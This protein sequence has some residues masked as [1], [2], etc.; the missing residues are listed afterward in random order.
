MRQ[1]RL[2]IATGLLVIGLDVLVVAAVTEAAAAS[3]C[4]CIQ[5]GNSCVPDP[6]CEAL[7]RAQQAAQRA[8]D[9][10]RRAQEAAQR[11]QEAAQRAQEA[12]QRAQDERSRDDER[13]SPEQRSRQSLDSPA[14]GGSPPPAARPASPPATSPPPSARAPPRNGSAPL[15]RSRPPASAN[16]HPPAAAAPAAPAAPGPQKSAKLRILETGYSHLIELGKEVD[17]YGLY[18]YAIL[19]SDSDR[20]ALFLGE[21]FKEIPS[22][23]GTSARPSQLNI[24]YIPLRKDKEADLVAMLRTPGRDAGK[25]GAEYTKSFYDYR[26]AR[27][28]LDHVCNPPDPSVLDLCDGALSGGPYIFA[29]ASPASKMEPVPPPFLFVDLSD[30][31]ERAF[32]EFLAAFQAQVKREDISDQARI[33]TLRLRILDIALTAADWVG[34]V[35]KAVADIARSAGGDDKK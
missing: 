31:H 4:P 28:L 11:A 16:G 7:L 3:D 22:I 26:M 15:A 13:K 20:A 23:G 29:Y 18:S 5:T 12:A 14:T 6:A 30:V 27:A 35:Q 8:Q 21:V 33:R 2:A 9:E 34:P 1:L 25:I 19:P 17:G 24:F 32:G 10:A